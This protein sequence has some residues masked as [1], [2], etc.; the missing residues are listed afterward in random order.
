MDLAGPGR[1]VQIELVLWPEGTGRLL[2]IDL[3]NLWC[4]APRG[5]SVDDGAGKGLV[6]CP[7][8]LR[9]LGQDHLVLTRVDARGLVEQRRTPGSCFFHKNHRRVPNPNSCEATHVDG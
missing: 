4:G 1:L 2:E 6:V 8:S 7:E 9:T 3:A 5:R